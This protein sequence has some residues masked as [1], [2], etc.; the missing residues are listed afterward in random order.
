MQS[1]LGLQQME[2]DDAAAELLLSLLYQQQTMQQSHGLVPPRGFRLH[3]MSKALD[4]RYLK[5]RGCRSAEAAAPDEAAANA[6]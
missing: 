1:P 6:P 3:G 4:K 2:E 5:Q